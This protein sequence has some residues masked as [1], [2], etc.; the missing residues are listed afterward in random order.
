MVVDEVPGQLEVGEGGGPLVG[1]LQ[2][3]VGLLR[4]DVLERRALGAVVDLLAGVGASA[5]DL[6]AEPGVAAELG[7][8]AVVEGQAVLEREAE[9]LG[10]RVQKLLVLSRAGAVA[11]DLEEADVVR[12]V[13]QCLEEVGGEGAVGAPRGREVE[14]R[15]GG[16]CSAHGSSMRPPV[17]GA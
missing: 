14:D 4:G 15:D 2:A 5:G 11:G 8:G 10:D 13:A 17:R 3:Q 6:G 1:A 9:E 7:R 16:S 12:G